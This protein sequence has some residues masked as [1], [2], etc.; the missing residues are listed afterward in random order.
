[1][2]D[3]IGYLMMK[4]LYTVVKLSNLDK[5]WKSVMAIKSISSTQV[6]NNFGRVLDDI[7]HNHTRYIVKRRNIPQVIMLDFDDFSRILSDAQERDRMSAVLKALR[8]EYH[9]GQIFES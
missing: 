8:P 7:T 3:G 2:D 1:M 6:Q 9:L 5:L 4:C